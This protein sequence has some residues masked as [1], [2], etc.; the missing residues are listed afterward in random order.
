MQDGPDEYGHDAEGDLSLW[1]GNLTHTL[2]VLRR[3]GLIEDYDVMEP[4]MYYTNVR[5]TAA[6]REA[7]R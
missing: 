6:G 1:S 4:D 5:L 2:R 3:R 7:L